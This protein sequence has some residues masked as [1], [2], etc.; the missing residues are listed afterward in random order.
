MKSFISFFVSLV[1]TFM[2]FG[3]FSEG[4]ARDLTYKIAA[5]YRQAY[6]SARV[7]KA[8]AFAPAQV[9]GLDASYGIAPDLQAGAY[10]GFE[11]NMDFVMV[12]PTLRYDIQRLFGRDPAIWDHLNL[13]VEA[14]FLA[15]LGKATKAGITI[16]AP[17]M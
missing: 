4:E 10:F 9:N 1:L 17:Y 8:K 16:H 12:G 13:F 15:K 3:F 7:N 11:G 2:A 6:T 5:G 14:K